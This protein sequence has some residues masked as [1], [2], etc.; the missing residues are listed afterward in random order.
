M[1]IFV[2]YYMNVTLLLHL[3][4]LMQKNLSMLHTLSYVTF[5]YGWCFNSY[6]FL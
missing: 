6:L 3:F 4:C 5:T 2:S 1:K